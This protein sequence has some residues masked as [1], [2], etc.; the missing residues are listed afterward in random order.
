VGAAF[1]GL[2]VPEPERESV[3]GAERPLLLTDNPEEETPV[4]AG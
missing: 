4:L 2:L 1:E 3:A